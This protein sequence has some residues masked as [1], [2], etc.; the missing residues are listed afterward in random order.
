M[1]NDSNVLSVIMN[2]RAFSA[3][4]NKT[5]SAER[6]ALCRREERSYI[7]RKLF[8]ALVVAM[9]ATPMWASVTI[10]AT[11]LGEGVVAIDYSSDDAELVR[12]FALD[13]TVDAGTIEAVGDFNVGDDNHGYGI[14]PGNFSRYITVDPV[15]G[16]VSDWGVDG[17]TPVADGNDPGALG[18][19]GTSGITIEMG[20]LY[21]TKA[22]P[23]QGRLCTVTCSETCL[24]TVTTNA[25]RGNVVLE[26]ASEATVDLTG[27]TN[28]PVNVGAPESYTGPQMDEWVA[29]G[30]PDCWCASINP[31]QCH[32][33]A[34]GQSQGKNKYWVS[35]N[36]LNILIEAW[37]KPL[38]SLTGNQIC[39]DFD[40]LPQGKNKY[41]VST[42]DLNILIA[43]WQLADA[44][45]PDCP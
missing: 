2:K 35:T 38:E 15:S 40:H 34:D 3:A 4:G 12:A 6:V 14:F 21:D 45:A 41:R 24:L 22:P 39:A 13:I 16:E 23:K 27:A 26:D 29:V 31:R 5:E 7:M 19:L 25:T 44:P 43:N 28:Y 8:F 33:D 37:N 20:S 42:N 11:D 1:F 32:G 10:T 30:K 17:Y 36:D 9:L 18:G